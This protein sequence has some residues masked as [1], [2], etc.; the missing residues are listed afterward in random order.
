M[1]VLDPRPKTRLRY[2]RCS[3]IEGAMA[4]G[5]DGQPVFA[6]ASMSRAFFTDARWLSESA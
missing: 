5:E 2:D 6:A 1:L 4:D 3:E